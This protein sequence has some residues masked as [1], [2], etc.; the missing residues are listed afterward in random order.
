MNWKINLI[1][2]VTTFTLVFVGASAMAASATTIYV[3]DNY[4]TIQEAVNTSNN[5][6]I[7]IVRGGTYTENIEV[8]KSLTIRSENGS[9]FTTIIATESDLHILWVAADYVDIMDLL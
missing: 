3:P 7:I 6:D 4:V 1:A 5:V 2:L 9:A 8:D